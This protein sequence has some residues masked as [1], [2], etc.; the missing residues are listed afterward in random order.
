M[1][2]PNNPL[3]KAL[4]RIKDHLKC[5]FPGLTDKECEP[6]MPEIRAIVINYGNEKR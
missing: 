2:D 5:A 1:P 4:R 3:E 6:I